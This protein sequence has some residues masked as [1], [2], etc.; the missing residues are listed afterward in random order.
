MYQND[1]P[2]NDMLPDVRLR[3]C[4][5]GNRYN[6]WHGSTRNAAVVVRFLRQRVLP[7]LQTTWL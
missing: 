4:G 1:T 3:M 7:N 2:L 5:M 6:G